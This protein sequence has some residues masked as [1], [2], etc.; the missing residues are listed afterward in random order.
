[1]TANR[2][3]YD[4]PDALTTDR[5]DDSELIGDLSERF[6]LMALFA[7]LAYR[8]DIDKEKR[9]EIECDRSL[10]NSYGLPNSTV[11]TIGDSTD[12]LQWSRWSPDSAIDIE[13][14]V[15][16]SGLFADT[17][18]LTNSSDEILEA[19]I[20]YRGTEVRSGQTFKDVAATVYNFFGFEPK[21]YEIA[22]KSLQLVLSAIPETARVYAT[23]HSLGGGLAQQ[24]GYLNKRILEVYTFNTSPV[25]NW[26]SLRRKRLVMNEFP[27]IYRIY[28]TG[29]FLQ[30]IRNVTTQLTSS[31]FGRFDIGLQVDSKS[32]AKG[33][34]LNIITCSVLQRHASLKRL[35]SDANHWLSSSQAEQLVKGANYQECL[36]E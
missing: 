13:P 7:D 12:T 21:Q 10:E 35:A 14:C 36:D 31:R 16:G 34:S 25:T 28:H 24:A 5:V 17:F 3:I 27:T 1:M 33:H 19:V 6:A 11:A 22:Q 32:L 30:A 23:G 29:E 15:N 20:A 9:T 18:V 2:A 26:S 4:N 8:R